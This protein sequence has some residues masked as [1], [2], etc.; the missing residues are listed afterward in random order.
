MFPEYRSLIT[1]LKKENP[2]FSVLFQE[3]NELDHRIKRE[4]ER[5]AADHVQIVAMKKE[6][7]RLKDEMYQIL[8]SYLPGE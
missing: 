6:K 7:L 4:E 1:R 5:P 8:K 3:H 2:H